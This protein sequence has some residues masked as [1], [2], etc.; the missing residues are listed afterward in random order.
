MQTNA[1]KLKQALICISVSLG[2]L[3]L[4]AQSNPDVEAFAFELGRQSGSFYCKGISLESAVEKGTMGAALAMDLPMSQLDSM[5]L[6][7]DQAAMALIE[8]L[9]DTA[10]DTCPQRAKTIFREFAALGN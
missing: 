10:I 4:P 5:D 1:F 7:S 2:A 8:G 6:S 3:V 9:L